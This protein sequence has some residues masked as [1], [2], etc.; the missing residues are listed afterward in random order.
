MPFIFPASMLDNM[1]AFQL[2]EVS[3][4]RV[5]AKALAG[6][7]DKIATVDNKSPIVEAAEL[8]SYPGTIWMFSPTNKLIPAPSSN[9]QYRKARKQLQKYN[10]L[11]QKGQ[12]FVINRPEDLKIIL[13]AVSLDLTKSLKQLEN[14]V[15]EFS[16]AWYDGKAD[17]IF[18]FQKGKMYAYHLILKSLAYDFKEVLLQKELYAL[19]TSLLKITEDAA[20]LDPVIV[21]NAAV[22]SVMGTNHLLVMECYT[23]KA[24]VSL[25]KML[26]ALVMEQVSGDK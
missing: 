26:D 9:S 2:G 22:D 8:L 13:Q 11:L 21:R 17:D 10:K 20:L 24:V 1:P 25:R 6:V 23:L 4:I 3:A 15:R 14:R 12:A 19:W 5:M 16:D 7:E 18:Y